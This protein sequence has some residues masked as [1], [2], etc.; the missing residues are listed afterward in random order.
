MALSN[1]NNDVIYQYETNS[2]TKKLTNLSLISSLKAKYIYLARLLKGF[3]VFMI[4][5]FQTFYNKH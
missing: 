3:G 1:A 4:I 5:T 2:F